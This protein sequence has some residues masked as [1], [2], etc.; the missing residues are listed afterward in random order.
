MLCNVTIDKYPKLYYTYYRTRERKKE[1]CMNIS[2]G[3]RP[4]K[5]KESSLET[6][7]IMQSADIR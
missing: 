2:S 7:L 5:K 3:N 1:Q 4:R 6:R